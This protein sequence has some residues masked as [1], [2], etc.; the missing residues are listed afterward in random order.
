MKFI[1]LRKIRMRRVAFARLRNTGISISS[2]T[3]NMTNAITVIASI[4]QLSVDSAAM[5][6]TVTQNM[7][8]MW[9]IRRSHKPLPLGGKV[10][11][12]MGRSF[13]IEARPFV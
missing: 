3:S 9:R 5:L 13:V 11:T 7:L 1:I 8:C 6:I 12:I 4:L 10:F 2:T